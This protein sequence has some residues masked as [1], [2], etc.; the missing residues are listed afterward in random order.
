MTDEKL[1]EL[2]KT[3]PAESF[4]Y[5]V[6]EYTALVFTICK[7]TLVPFGTVEDAQ[8]CASD[9]FYKFY[10]HIETVDLSKGSIKGYLAVCAK[11][12]AISLLRKLKR[13]SN[14]ISIDDDENA[15]TLESQVST[16]KEFD[17]KAILKAVKSLGEP[18]SEIILRRFY[19]GETASQIAKKLKMKPD[20][21]QKKA[22]RA[23]EKLRRI[24]EGEMNE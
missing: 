20:A 17:K 16:E 3:N 6:E 21:V 8:E 7:N 10:T 19:L 9:T 1:L 23:E 12:N 11:R 5:L 24:L 2:L 4:T 14:V 15:I 18:D 22:K 13:E